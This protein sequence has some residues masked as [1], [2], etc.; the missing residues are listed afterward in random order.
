MSLAKMEGEFDRAQLPR[1]KSQTEIDDL[2]NVKD[3]LSWYE[4]KEKQFFKDQDEQYMPVIREITSSLKDI[5]EKLKQ[6]MKANSQREDLAKLKESEFYLDLEELDRLNKE[7]DAEIQKIREKD[8]LDNLSKIYVRE[9]IKR[10]CWDQMKIKGQGIQ[11]FNSN[12]LVENYALRERTREELAQLERCK[13]V[14]RIE[15]AGQ[16]SRPDF[17]IDPSKKD[18][19]ILSL[20]ET[21]EDE[22][23][24]KDKDQQDSSNKDA[25]ANQN[26]LSP[27]LLHLASK[28][29]I[30]SLFNGDSNLFYNQFELYTREQKWIQI[31]LIQDAIF[32]I[33]E[34]FNREFEQISQRKLQEIGK[35]REKNQRLKQI[36][37]DLNEE[38]ALTEPELGDQENAELL[39]EVKDS[40]VRP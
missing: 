29:S 7:S 24:D 23:K 2:K 37:I 5:K 3:E 9:V 19:L 13:F 16:K 15:I 17:V 31:T 4:M 10:E 32:R 35:I 18:S 40:E 28:G 14:R 20:V 11:A 33:K 22:S 30:G 1:L 6:L 8:E 27:N 25:A 12:L 34:N 38:K 21:D 39:F 36:Y 26:Y